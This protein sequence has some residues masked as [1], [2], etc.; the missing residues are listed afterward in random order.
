V[1]VLLDTG[2]LY[3]CYD[4]TDAW[5]S[6]SVELIRR[7]KGQLVVPAPVIPEVDHLLGRRL[8]APA[9]LSFYEG[10]VSGHYFVAELSREGY[11]RVAELNRRF[12]ELSLGFVDAAVIA[13][14]EGLGLLR[15]ATNDRRDFEPLR[16]PLSLELLP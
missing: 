3:A 8:G 11:A 1:A 4:R 16:G 6:R 14:G 5:H 7:E 10:L 13:I 15:I 2:V 9:R 12:S